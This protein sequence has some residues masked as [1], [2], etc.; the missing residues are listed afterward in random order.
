MI[1]YFSA[2]GN[3]KYVAQSMANKNETVISISEAINNK[4]EIDLSKEQALGIISPVYDWGLPIIVHDFLEKVKFSFNE[5]PYT[6]LIITYGTTTGQCGFYVNKLLK[7]KGLPL[8][9]RFSIQFPD[10]WTPIFN[11]SDSEAVKRRLEN[12]E[13]E[14]HVV[15]KHVEAKDEG[16]FMNRKAPK[17]SSDT[18]QFF[19]KN[20]VRKTSHFSVEDSCIGCGFCEKNC[21]VSA[22]K[23]KDGKPQWVA[24]KCVMCLGC[25]HR[26]PKFSIQY[27]KKTKKHGQYTNPNTKM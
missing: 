6:Y 22:I 14:L 27:G 4:T 16:D 20:V 25:L 19:Y 2:T 3:C 5:K 21:P 7:D 12:A 1:I 11:L 18:A 13:N 17:L 15:K 26:C 8:N 10:T 23:I 9:G 24:D